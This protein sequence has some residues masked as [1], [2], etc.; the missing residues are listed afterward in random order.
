MAGSKCEQ[1]PA[2]TIKCASIASVNASVA[3]GGNLSSSNLHGRTVHSTRVLV[4]YPT[5]C[6]MALAFGRWAYRVGKV[7]VVIGGGVAMTVGA[8]MWFVDYQVSVHNFLVNVFGPSA[9]GWFDVAI[10]YVVALVT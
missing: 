8:A 4:F 9:A 7:G 2:N 3:V 10:K 5:R 1:Q 6:N